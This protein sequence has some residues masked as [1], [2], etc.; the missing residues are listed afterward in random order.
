MNFTKRRTEL[1]TVKE[2]GTG[3]ITTTEHSGFGV[4]KY[5]LPEIEVGQCYTVE[6]YK[7]NQVAGVIKDGEY[8]FHRSDEYFADQLDRFI[9]DNRRKEL[10]HWEKNK[11]DWEHRTNLLPERYKNRLNRFRN[12]EDG[13]KFEQ[14]GLG[15]G[16]ELIC[17]ELAVQYEASGGEDNEDVMTIARHYGTSGNQHDVAKAWAKY[18]DKKI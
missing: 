12:A 10:E 4:P 9:E 16:Y 15:W 13:L 6:F 7:F 17:C 14:Q 18:P 5:I 3:S 11:D 1:F 2:K 8:L